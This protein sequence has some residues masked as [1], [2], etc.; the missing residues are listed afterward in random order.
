MKNTTVNILQSAVNKPVDVSPTA[1]IGVMIP[2]L[3]C[4]RLLPAHIESMQSWLHFVSEII[5]VDSHSNDDTVEIIREQLKHPALRVFQHPRGLYQSWNFG[6]SQITSQY[7]YISTVGDSISCAGLEHLC[8]VAERFQCDGVISRPRAIKDDGSAIHNAYWPIN[9]AI[10]SLGIS[11]PVLPEP[12]ELFLF[13]LLHIPNAILGSSASNLYR[14]AI[15]Q[16]ASFPTDFGTV[17]DAAWAVSNILDC[18]FAVTPEIFSTFRDHPK[19]YPSKEYA[20][21]DLYEKSFNLARNTL[22]QRSSIDAAL[23]AKA[24]QMDFE[25]LFCN[26]GEYLKWRRRLDAERDRK[27]PWIFKPH[28]W[29]FRAERNSFH[30][31]LQEHKKAVIKSSSAV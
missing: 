21:A 18:R 4:A 31:R 12:I 25:R 6:I 24:I 2:T 28:A 14:T 26:L 17:G 3:N 1:T 23:R 19:A 15:L 29:R 13:A 22:E 27:L 5:V 16:R 9:D 8:A 20:V 10:I 7:T 11:E 30:R